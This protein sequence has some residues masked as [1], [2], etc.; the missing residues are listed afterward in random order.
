[1]ANVWGR[2]GYPYSLMHECRSRGVAA[3][4]LEESEAPMNAYEQVGA[5]VWRRLLKAESDGRALLEAAIVRPATDGEAKKG[6]KKQPPIHPLGARWF[7]EHTAPQVYQRRLELTG[8]L[9]HT[10]QVNHT[11]LHLTEN[12]QPVPKEQLQDL[13]EEVQTLL[14]AGGEEAGLETVEA[15]DRDGQPVQADLVLY[16]GGAGAKV[17]TG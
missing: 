16:Q 7:L 6:R 14:L 4:L 1:M 2:E 17:S 11:H 12:G 5:R 13:L 10:G 8:A 9:D 15:L 3:I